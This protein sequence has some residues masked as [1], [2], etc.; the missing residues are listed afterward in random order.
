MSDDADAWFAELSEALTGAL[1][2]AARATITRGVLA[3]LPVSETDD[4]VH[5]LSFFVRPLGIPHLGDGRASLLFVTAAQLAT[6]AQKMPMF[7]RAATSAA[8]QYPDL[9]PPAWTVLLAEWPLRTPGGGTVQAH[10]VQPIRADDVGAD[11]RDAACALLAQG[12]HEVAR[13]PAGPAGD[14][15]YVVQRALTVT[16]A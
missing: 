15:R 14:E 7:A 16:E 13:N 11:V 2:Q 4:V 10:V 5:L 12:I 3:L 1:Q 6:L 9:D 8:L